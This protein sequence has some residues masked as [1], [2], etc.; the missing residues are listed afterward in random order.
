MTVGPDREWYLPFIGAIVPIGFLGFLAFTLWS[1]KLYARGAICT[2]A[3]NPSVYWTG[4]AFIVI[5]LVVTVYLWTTDFGH[6][7]WHL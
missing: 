7:V 4:V 6:W 3:E 5:C 2:R 1:G